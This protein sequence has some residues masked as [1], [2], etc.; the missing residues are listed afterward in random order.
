MWALAAFAGVFTLMFTVFLTNPSGLWDGLYESIAYWIGQ[1]GVG[2]GG[3][4]PYFYVVVLFAHEWP[5]LLLGLLG[6]VFAF[7]QPTRAARLPRVGVRAVAGDLLVG[8]RE[9]RLARAAPAAAADPAGRRRRAVAV[10]QPRDR[11]RPRRH[12]G[13][14]GDRALRA[15]LA[16]GGR[17]P[18]TARTRGSSSSPPSPPSEVKQVADQVAGDGAQEPEAVGDHRLRRR[19]DVPLRL[20][21]P[22]PQ[23]RLPRLHAGRPA[24]GL[25]RD[26]HHRGRPRAA[27]Q[28]ARRL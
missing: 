7:R 20:V 15:D 16:R 3:E 26:D 6:A 25:R 14:R 19:R 22:R 23:R 2:R 10:G 4:K 21:L 11:A 24:A 18:S 17:T 9:V 27:G 8:G 5:V 1:H 28:H 12:R 13:R